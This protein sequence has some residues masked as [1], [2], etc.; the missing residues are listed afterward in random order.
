MKIPWSTF[1]IRGVAYTYFFR[2]MHINTLNET[3]NRPPYIL[4]AGSGN[5]TW[6]SKVV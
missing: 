1:N 2:S 6:W 4:A 5:K 3:Y